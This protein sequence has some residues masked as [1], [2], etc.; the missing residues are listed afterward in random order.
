[1]CCSRAPTSAWATSCRASSRRSSKDSLCT[2]KRE[3]ASSFFSESAIPPAVRRS[4]RRWVQSYKP[5]DHSRYATY[6]RKSIRLMNEICYSV[7]FLRSSLRPTIVVLVK[8]L[9]SCP[10]SRQTRARKDRWIRITQMRA[11]AAVTG[12]DRI[13]SLYASS[14]WRT[15]SVASLIPNTLQPVKLPGCVSATAP[16]TMEGNDFKFLSGPVMASATCA[17]RCGKGG[18][19]N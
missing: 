17:T 4:F 12:F 15:A 1:M 19:G 11:R 2:A 16:D 6:P 8:F 3:K 7:T 18:G 9:Y 5:F 10:P 13:P 14:L